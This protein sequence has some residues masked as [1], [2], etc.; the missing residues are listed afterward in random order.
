MVGLIPTKGSFTVPGI[1]ISRIEAKER[2]DHLFVHSYD[3]TL[4][5]TTGAEVF[6]SKSV[7]K[8]SCNAPG[9]STFIDACGRSIISAT[10][11]GSPVDTSNFDG[12]SVFLHNL[13]AENE[14]IIEIEAIYSKSG[15]GLQRSVDP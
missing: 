8:F 7:T 1:N 5:V 11:N 10:L 13:A 6:Y 2:A 14:L 12:E 9:Y 4:D 3:V 15:E